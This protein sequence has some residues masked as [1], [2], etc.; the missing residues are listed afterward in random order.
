LEADDWSDEEDFF[1][2]DE[3]P[4]P[5]ADLPTA[6]RRI[7]LLEKKLAQS[8][9]DMAE[10]RALVGQ[11]FDAGRLAEIVNEPG[12]SS[13]AGPTQRDDDTHYFSSY[14]ENGA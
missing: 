10:Y 14:C 9:K 1:S 8:H 6:L 3:Q 7:E 4:A 2:S 5:P 11:Q 13:A 12:P